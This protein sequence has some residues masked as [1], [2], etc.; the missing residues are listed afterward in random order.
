MITISTVRYI[1]DLARI[2]LSDD[3]LS[4]YTRELEA[5]LNYISKLEKISIQDV[6]PT[7]HALPLKNVYRPDSLAPSL[8]T[9]EALSIAVSQQAGFFKVPQV[10]E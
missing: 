6:G 1:A 7:S 2:A 4:Q 9:A 8:A 3:E 10:I 5:I